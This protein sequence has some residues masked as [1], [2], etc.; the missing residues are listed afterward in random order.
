M[1]NNSM[2]ALMID[3]DG[4][5][6]NGR[7][8]DGCHWSTDMEQHLGI[9]VKNLQNAFFTPYWAQI[10][11]G[12]LNLVSALKPVLL[13]LA[14]HLNVDDFITY[15][16]ENDARLNIDLINDLKAY[17]DSGLRLCLATNQEHMRAEY[18][19]QTLGLS[20]KV[21][22]IY[23][24]A[25][26][27]VKKPDALFFEKVTQLSNLLP[28]EIVLIDDTMENIIAAKYTGW[29]A[30]HWTNNSCLSAELALI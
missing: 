6:I 14:P 30:I 12:K 4:V 16:F 9:S 28:E 25:A 17:R 5:L 26:L 1:K 7:L 22:E 2:K 8:E 10:V 29:K 23:Y 11:T 3:V 27:G 24:S 13:Q 18:I 19:A 21:D 15:W 20:S